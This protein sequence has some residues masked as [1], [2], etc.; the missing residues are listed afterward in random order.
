M[1]FE[2]TRQEQVFRGLTD[3][4]K[5]HIED[6]LLYDCIGTGGGTMPAAGQVRGFNSSKAL[7]YA[8]LSYFA[9]QALGFRRLPFCED[10]IYV[11]YFRRV[12][13]SKDVLAQLDHERVEHI[14]AETKRLYEH[15]QTALRNSGLTSVNIKRQIGGLNFDWMDR[16]ARHSVHGYA[17]TF[18]MLQHACDALNVSEFNVEM[19]T[20]NSFSD[21]E[22][23]YHTDVRIE[24][25]VPTK[26]IFYCSALIGDRANRQ[27]PTVETGEWIV[28]NRSPTGVLPLPTTSLIVRQDLWQLD[29]QRSAEY[30]RSFLDEH[31]PIVL[32][33]RYI[34]LHRMSTHGVRPTL[35]HRLAGRL[36]KLMMTE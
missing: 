27:P 1:T 29:R 28:I 2:I 22:D 9:S 24:L 10:R 11:D 13:E 32:R 17:E 15:T 16:F 8:L 25:E 23:T 14:V 36:L 7:G 6:D 5:F 18:V 4:D 33:P 34:D 21:Q 35:K 31:Q 20:L 30:F 12:E 26:D 3:A 19:D